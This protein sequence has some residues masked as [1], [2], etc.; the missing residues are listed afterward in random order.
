[1]LVVDKAKEE[2]SVS[3]RVAAN[4]KIPLG[5]YGLSLDVFQLAGAI[6]KRCLWGTVCYLETLL[7][8]HVK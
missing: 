6:I 2:L 4:N 5:H 1:M 7:P 8:K 3:D